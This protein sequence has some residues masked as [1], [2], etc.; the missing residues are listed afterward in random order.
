MVTLDP[1]FMSLIP[2]LHPVE[3]QN[4][5]ESLLK[6]GCRDTLI[7]WDSILLDGHNRHSICSKHGIPYQ[8]KAIILPDRLAA[9]IWI[10]HNQAARR[11]LT[12]DQRAM[13]SAALGELLSEQARVERARKARAAVVERNPIKKSDLVADV[14][15]ESESKDLIQPK[16][17]RTR[18]QAAKTAGVSEWKVRQAQTV[19]KAAP[20]LAEKVMAGEVSLSKAMAHIRQSERKELAANTV[21]GKFNVILADPPWQ[22]QNSGFIESAESLYPTMKTEDICAMSQQIHEWATDYTAL[23]LWATNPMLPDALRVMQ[24]WGFEYKTNMCWVKDMGRGKGWFLKS[25]HELLLIGVK[26]KT[27]QPSERPDSAFLADRPEQHSR[28]PGLSYS[29]IEG[30]Y[31]GPRL[32]MFSRRSR[33]G[34]EHFGNEVDR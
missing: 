30:M 14:S 2:K 23:F 27:P 33:D 9:K 13:N 34:W 19:R 8:T 15:S 29:L 3:L 21:N 18:T 26:P 22:Y 5:E 32:E 6:E 10:R 12:D 20:D 24:A 31:G 28:K 16:P 17:E 4:L 25:R 11:N 7:T 1:E